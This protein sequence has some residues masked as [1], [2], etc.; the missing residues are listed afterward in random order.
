MMWRTFTTPIC[1]AETVLRINNTLSYSQPKLKM[2]R[3]DEP[4]TAK[5]LWR[6]C[7]KIQFP[8]SFGQFTPNYAETVH[9]HKI[10]TPW[11]QLKLLYFS[12]W[13]A[14]R[15]RCSTRNTGLKIFE[16]FPEKYQ[17]ITL[18][19]RCF[20]GNFPIQKLFLWSL[21]YQLKIIPKWICQLTPFWC[22]YVSAFLVAGIFIL[23]METC[24][25]QHFLNFQYFLAKNLFFN[26]YKILW[27][28][29]SWNLF[30]KS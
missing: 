15:P 5:L 8:N 29:R 11:N 24:D 21:L 23:V 6:F 26:I 1:D 16:K 10:S 4:D 12:Q 14:V 9:F 25:I 28:Q 17:L 18:P 22:F 7:G 30:Q 19:C 13:E 27:K 2:K 3:L 20:L